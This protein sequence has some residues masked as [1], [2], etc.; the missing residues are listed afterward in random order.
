MQEGFL[1]E[2]EEEEETRSGPGWQDRLCR[3]RGKGILG[4]STATAEGWQ[5]GGAEGGHV[6]LR[7]CSE[8]TMD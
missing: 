8:L 3:G 1:E 2:E 7:G 6:A 5:E 4:V